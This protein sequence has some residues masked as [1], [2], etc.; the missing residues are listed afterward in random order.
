MARVTAERVSQTKQ[1]LLD[2]ARSV[3]TTDGFSGL[4]I[5]RVAEAAGTQ[6]SQI[7][8][9][10]GSKEGL[11]LALFKHMNA[12]L[13]ERQAA[14][15]DD[16]DISLSEKWAL[17]CDY[18]EQDLA[19]GYVRVLQELIAAGWSNPAIGDAVRDALGHWHDLLTELA[20]EFGKLQGNLGPF[21]PEEIASLVS[22]SFIGAEALI[23][24]GNDDANRLVHQ[25]LRRFGD[26]IEIFEKQRYKE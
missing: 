7:R 10:F 18:L 5:R 3:L 9:H 23:L 26:A 12:G 16:P 15:F 2:A 4:S 19:S 6:M 14:T 17:S 22:S 24:L 1:E 13:I 20:R 11:I 8:Y 21:S 25:A